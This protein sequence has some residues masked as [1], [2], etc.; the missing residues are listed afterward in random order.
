[1]VSKYCDSLP[2]YRQV[3]MLGRQGV[4]LDRSTLSNWVGRGCWWLTPIYDLV[5]GTVLSSARIWVLLFSLPLIVRA[6]RSR[7][8]TWTFWSWRAD[9]RDRYHRTGDECGAR[10]GGTRASRQST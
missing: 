7:I 2:L 5:V 8:G 4:T 10:S 1:V 3:Q 6:F 9:E